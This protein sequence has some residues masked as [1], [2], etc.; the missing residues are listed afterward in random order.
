VRKFLDALTKPMLDDIVDPVVQQRVKDKLKELGIDDPKKAFA[1]K[2]NHPFIITKTGQ[3]IPI[4]KVRIRKSYQ[5][6]TVGEGPRAR[7]IIPGS[8]HH[9]EIF[10]VKDKKGKVKWEGRMV[11]MI[12]AVRRLKA[13][14]PV[15]NRE[16]KGGGKWVFSLAGGEIIEIDHADG[17]RWW[18]RIRTISEGKQK[19]IMAAFVSVNDARLKADILKA[20]DFYQKLLDPLRELNCQKVI[21]TPLGE[22]RTA[23]D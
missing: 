11:N 6:A 21:I 18:Y 20:G 2:K 4:H 22:V 3:K 7:L 13:K 10:E 5:V 19:R 15:I 12:E 14:E 9:I 8:N 17:T 1:D 23:N 16:H